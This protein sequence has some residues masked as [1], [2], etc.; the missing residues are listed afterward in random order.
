M[1]RVA[2]VIIATGLLVSACGVSSQQ[3]ESAYATALERGR[4]QGETCLSR[5]SEAPA[6]AVERARCINAAEEPVIA[7]S[8]V[9]DLMRL[10]ASRR[11]E[12]AEMR[13]AGRMSVAEADAH[14]AEL[15]TYIAT[16]A[17]RR[18]RGGKAA[19]AT[20]QQQ[21]RPAGPA[22]STLITSTR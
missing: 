5:Y 6:E 7:M 20:A 8:T 12:L 9:P 22:T 2:I 15:N 18:E 13:A 21:Q 1:S 10:R 3:Q 14:M 19:P 11:L 4:A 17:Q 16:E